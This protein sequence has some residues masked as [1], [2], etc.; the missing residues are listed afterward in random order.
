MKKE[1][2][3]RGVGGKGGEKKENKSATRRYEISISNHSGLNGKKINR[4]ATRIGSERS[5][6]EPIA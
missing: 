3:E 4:T 1:R 2:G 6:R 5:F